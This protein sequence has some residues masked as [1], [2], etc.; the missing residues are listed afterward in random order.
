MPRFP[1]PPEVLTLVFKYAITSIYLIDYS[2]LAGPYGGYYSD[3][4]F[5]KGL[6]HVCRAWHEAA[7]QVLYEDVVFRRC[8]QI[9]MFLD[10]L[11]KAPYLG[12]VVK[13]IMILCPP[14][15]DC[16]ERFTGDI[17]KLYGCCPMATHIEYHPSFYNSHGPEGSRTKDFIPPISQNITHFT[18]GK[19]VPYA[20]VAICLEPVQGTLRSLSFVLG[21]DSQ[22]IPANQKLSFPHLDT[23]AVVVHDYRHDQWNH[24][25]RWEVTSLTHLTFFSLRGCAADEAMLELIKQSGQA[26]RFL[27]I[28]TTSGLV[29]CYL[30]VCPN[31]EHLVIPEN[32]GYFEFTK[33]IHPKIRWLDVWPLGLNLDID[34]LSTL[35]DVNHLPSL[36]GVRTFHVSFYQFFQLPLV[37]PPDLHAKGGP[38]SNSEYDNLQLPLDLCACWIKREWLGYTFLHP[39]RHVVKH[40]DQVLD[41]LLEKWCNQ[42]GEHT[43]SNLE[44]QIPGMEKGKG[45]EDDDDPGDDWIPSED[46][47]GSDS[48]E[49]SDPNDVDDV[50]DITLEERGSLGHWYTST[51]NLPIKYSTEDMVMRTHRHRFK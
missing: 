15:P 4:R 33:L 46:D 48:S 12:R 40:P 8:I 22:P 16:E 2:P 11:A 5:R 6:L 27:H 13:S 47:L 19:C 38:Q 42:V 26:L 49:G 20:V 1:L 36:Q 41:E 43:G 21:E 17:Q 18:F 37:Y 7:I 44:P 50:E 10:T 25:S 30:D 31:I 51:G 23:L 34:D 32:L 14:P 39:L 24:L 3:L 35:L 28:Q 45:L 9:P 29:Q